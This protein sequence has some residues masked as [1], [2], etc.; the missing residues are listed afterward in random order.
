MSMVWMPLATHSDAIT[1]TGCGVFV[2]A[3]LLSESFDGFP[4]V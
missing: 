4:R 2:S 1:L 3:L